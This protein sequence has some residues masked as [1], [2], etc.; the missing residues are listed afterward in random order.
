MVITV[1][2]F[3]ILYV[4]FSF[5]DPKHNVI[6]VYYQKYAIKNIVAIFRGRNTTICHGYDTLYEDTNNHDESYLLW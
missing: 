6:K 2:W 1:I 4:S 3:G 5:E